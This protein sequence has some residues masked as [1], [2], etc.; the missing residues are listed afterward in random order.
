MVKKA[1]K[2]KVIE[3]IDSVIY[4]GFDISLS[5]IAGCAKADDFVLNDILGP[6]WSVTRWNKEVSH[7]EKL[8]QLS[9]AHEFIFQLENK[10]KSFTRELSDFHI[11]VEEL[12]A[13]VM[14]SAR[15][16]EQAELNGAFIGGLLKYGYT[17]VY[18]VNVKSWQSMV[19]ADLEMKASKQAGFDKFKVAEWVE[20]VYGKKWKPLIRTSKGLVPKPKESKAKAEQ[21]DDRVDACGIM[22]W[23]Y[24]N[25]RN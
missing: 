9:N 19:A 2:P 11:G 5:S 22:E 20:E 12:P 21:P 6:A 18:S 7:W 24:A 25:R 4:I 10:L 23:V 1:F 14:N 16:R 13:R 8:K 17:K 3:K 15:Y